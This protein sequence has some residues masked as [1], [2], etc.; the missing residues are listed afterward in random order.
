MGTDGSLPDTGKGRT[1]PSSLPSSARAGRVAALVALFL[2]LSTLFGGGWWLLSQ[3]GDGRFRALAEHGQRISATVTRVEPQN[4]N[5]VYYKYYAEG[6]P[7]DSD[8]NAWPPNPEARDLK[9]GDKILV[10]YDVRNPGVSCACNPQE[11][12]LKR[13]AI[14]YLLIPGSLISLPITALVGVQV[15]R[16]RKSVPGPLP[17]TLRAHLSP[18]VGELL[19][20]FRR[21]G[22]WGAVT[23]IPGKIQ[24]YPNVRRGVEEGD[25][26]SFAIPIVHTNKE[27][28]LFKAD[29]GVV[30]QLIG[31]SA[32]GRA[33]TF[34]VRLR[35]LWDI[36][37]VKDL[38]EA[39]GFEVLEP[40]VLA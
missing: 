20:V 25:A 1:T 4:H 12:Y 5:T 23:L 27:V 9:P 8:G 31:D 18:R 28:Q 26:H 39:A 17:V 30:I 24:F 38:L 33:G 11:L 19:D 34:F 37:R 35:G 15:M 2:T 10:V 40:I 14:I 6:R 22:T 13:P 7:Y 32:M 3:W 29:R 36:Q 16:R 21:H